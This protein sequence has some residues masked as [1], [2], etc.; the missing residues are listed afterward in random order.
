MATTTAGAWTKK[1][2]NGYL[3]GTSAETT[4]LANAKIQVNISP[5]PSF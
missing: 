5:F 2:E 1:S 3:V 4:V